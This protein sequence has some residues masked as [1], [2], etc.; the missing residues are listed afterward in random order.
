MKATNWKTVLCFSNTLVPGFGIK[1]ILRAYKILNCCFQLNII[2]SNRNRKK[3]GI[4]F[5]F[6]DSKIKSLSL[7]SKKFFSWKKMLT[8]LSFGFYE[9]LQFA[10]R[11][12]LQQAI[13]LFFRSTKEVNSFFFQAGLFYFIFLGSFL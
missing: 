5:F 3:K 4:F 2:S 12:L 8:K 10:C 6:S 11:Q 9:Q 7:F 1:S 13:W